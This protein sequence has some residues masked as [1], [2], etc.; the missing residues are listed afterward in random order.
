MCSKL[1]TANGAMLSSL[2]GDVL[3]AI[4]MQ[5][6]DRDDRRNFVHSCKH[7]HSSPQVP[8][9]SMTVLYAPV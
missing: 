1:K 6:E 7:V 4:Y 8:Y 5:L 3:G 2:N 9:L